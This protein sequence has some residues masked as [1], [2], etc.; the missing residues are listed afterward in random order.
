MIDHPIKTSG[1]P[2]LALGVKAKFDAAEQQQAA[3]ENPASEKLIETPVLDPI[4]RVAANLIETRLRNDLNAVEPEKREAVLLRALTFSRLE[5]GHEF[6]YNR[7]FGSQIAALKRLNEVGRVTVDDARGF[8]RPYAEQFPQVYN[9]N[10]GFD[11][12]LAFLKES[13]LVVQ[14]G[15]FL[16]ITD[17]GRDFLIF[18]TERRLSEN[19]LW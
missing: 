7:I 8:L 2:C 16:E 13:G 17:I 12:W 18:L 4:P 9:S 1:R 3:A 11:N 19:K 15:N 10:Y 6:T 14:N 5:A